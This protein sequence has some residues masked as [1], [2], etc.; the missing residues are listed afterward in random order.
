MNKTTILS[1]YM[2][3]FKDKYGDWALVAGASEGLGAAFATALA[4]RGMNLVLIARRIEKLKAFS[5]QLQEKYGVK[6]KYKS[7][8]LA[9]F[10]AVKTW[11][12]ELELEIGL[13]VYNAAYVPIGYF[14]D[15]AMTDLQ[16]VVQVNIQT[17]LLLTKLLSKEMI[18]RQRGG[19]VLMSSLAGTQGSP[20]LA[21]YAASKAFNTILGEGLWQELQAKGIAVIASCAGAIRTP[22]YQTARNTKE[23]PGTLSATEVAQI[24]LEA[25][26]K[27]PI[28]TPGFTN[29]FVRFLMGRLLPRKIAIS[30][31][32]KN[33][34]SL[35]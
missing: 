26:G 10:E 17:P 28:V 14:E 16:K 11:M 30:I 31:M 7:I 18:N 13:L 35:N 12:T 9:N 23:A 6:I 8:D 2:T 3:L 29:K 19:I 15:V 25:L 22:G 1:K 4:E 24:T 5:H 21:T 33:S 32:A 27:G 34:K 20:K